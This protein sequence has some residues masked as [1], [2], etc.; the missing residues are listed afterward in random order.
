MESDLIEFDW[1]T[2]DGYKGIV[3]YEKVE[4]IQKALADGT[5]YILKDNPIR[6]IQEYCKDNNLSFTLSSVFSLA[7][8][9]ACGEL[10]EFNAEDRT[11][12]VRPTHMDCLGLNPDKVSLNAAYITDERLVAGKTFADIKGLICLYATD[13]QFEKDAETN[14]IHEQMT[15]NGIIHD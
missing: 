1:A 15:E 6:V 2:I 4:A 7:P 5:V 11:F 14:G 9:T 13:N 10:V 3:D 12:K 8:K